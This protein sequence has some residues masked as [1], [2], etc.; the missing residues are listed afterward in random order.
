MSGNEQTQAFQ[1]QT[2]RAPAGVP[3]A[4]AAAVIAIISALATVTLVRPKVGAAADSA[5]PPQGSRLEEVAP[6]EI[7]AALDTLAV[8]PEVAARF[9]AREECR[10]KLAW[11]T[12]ARLPD[13]PPGRIRLQSGKYVSPAF[14]LTELPVRVALPYPAPYPSGHGTIA[15]LGTSTDADVALTPVWKVAAQQGF[16]SREVSWT[17]AG[18]CPAANRSAD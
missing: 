9:R 16:Q 6:D 1:P 7:G 11:I 12:I 18:V 17:P 8:T 4:W 14:E 15:V 2:A 13:S 5:A 10:R 3:G